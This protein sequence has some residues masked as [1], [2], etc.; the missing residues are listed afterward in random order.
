M[1]NKNT[2]GS[3]VE[4]G[5][6]CKPK[7]LDINKPIMFSAIQIYVCAGD[8]CKTVEAE[9][10]LAEKLRIIIKELGY[11]AGDNRIKV[12]RTYCNGACRYKVFAHTYRNP[13]SPNA[14]VNN[15][16]YA[17]KKVHQLSDEQWKLLLI[18]LVKGEYPD[19]LNDYLV[20]TKVYDENTKPFSHK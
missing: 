12:T 8:R 6:A 5:Y 11:D 9:V 1:S 16:Y 7:Q 18:S 19:S 10:N 17:W 15:S 4:K 20:E 13:N 3:E 2:M 14:T